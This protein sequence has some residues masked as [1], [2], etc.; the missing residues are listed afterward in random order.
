MNSA[1]IPLSDVAGLLRAWRRTAVIRGV[2]AALLVALLLIAAFL[3]SRP[4]TRQ[5]LHLLPK[6]SNA[7]VVLDLSASISSD[8]FNRIGETLDQLAATNGRYGLVVFSDVAYE[9]LPPGTPSAQLRPFARYFKVP[10]QQTPGLAPAFPT[11][12]W[13]NS[14]SAGTRISAGLGLALRVIHADRLARPGVILISDLNDD[15]GDLTN[16][17]SSALAYRQE[18]IGIRI[19]A[20]NPSRDDQHRF[21][22]LLG[23]ASRITQAQ[24]P[25]D[26][27]AFQG[28]RFPLVLALLALAVALALA[29]NELFS[30]RLTWRSTA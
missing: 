12:P 11:N 9:A 4:T 5:P 16:L 23:N 21:E 2:L 13:T 18:G 29:A 17:A 28:A 20:L 3:S 24:L 6:A 30:A 25:G 26:R 22:T 8:T 27:T 15:Q 7:I 10:S 14:F 1:R 19:V